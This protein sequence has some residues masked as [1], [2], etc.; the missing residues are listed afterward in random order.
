[1]MWLNGKI[2]SCAII[3]AVDASAQVTEGPVSDSLIQEGAQQLA[4]VLLPDRSPPGPL[5]GDFVNQPIPIPSRPAQE[6]SAPDPGAETVLAPLAGP[7][8]S[9]DPF[10]W[11]E[12]HLLQFHDPL[13]YYA[14]GAAR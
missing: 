10:N 4:Q 9:Y 6:P 13:K 7:P 2:L 3:L 12:W 14:A 1:M 5:P 8:V 11:V